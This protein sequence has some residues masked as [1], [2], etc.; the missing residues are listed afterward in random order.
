[1]PPKTG[2]VTVLSKIAFSPAGTLIRMSF[3]SV[4]LAVTG[5]SVRVIVGMAVA[6]APFVNVAL[7]ADD[8][9]GLRFATKL[10]VTLSSTP[11]PKLSDPLV[12]SVS[13]VTTTFPGVES[14]FFT[15]TYPRPELFVVTTVVAAPTAPLLLSVITPPLFTLTYT[16]LPYSAGYPLL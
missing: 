1:M 10:I 11:S 16:F 2:F 9:V 13:S 7:L 5:E 15:F 12:P 6:A 4:M 8:I 14:P 3:A